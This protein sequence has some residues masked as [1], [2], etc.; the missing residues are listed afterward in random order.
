MHRSLVLHTYK[1]TFYPSLMQCQMNII[2]VEN[3]ISCLA[4]QS[5]TCAM[6]STLLQSNIG[7][8]TDTLAVC[9]CQPKH[10]RTTH[11]AATGKR[12]FKECWNQEWKKLG[13]CGTR[14]SEDVG[15]LFLRAVRSEHTII[16]APGGDY[17]ARDGDKENDGD[18]PLQLES[19]SH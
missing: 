8:C 15:S 19:G 5:W 7:Q 1:S 12:R 6:Q 3:I 9:C 2:I 18:Y 13:K 10:S 4:N 17:K 14:S 11:V 16:S